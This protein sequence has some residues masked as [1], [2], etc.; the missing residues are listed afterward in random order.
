MLRF[1]VKFACGLGVAYLAV[2]APAMANNSINPGTTITGASGTAT[3]TLTTALTGQTNEPDVTGGNVDSFWYTWV[4]PQTGNVVFG[5][6]NTT[7]D[8]TTNF[9]T[10]LGT[11]TS[12]VEPVNN[13]NLN[14]LTTVPNPFGPVNLLDDSTGCLNSAGNAF[15]TTN[16][17]AAVMGTTYHIRV[18][19]YQSTVGTAR[20]R[21]AYPALTVATTDNSATEG[22]PN[23]GAF[24][25]VANIFAHSGDITV[26]IGSSPQC[27]FSPTTL[28]FTP[29][30]WNV[31]QTVTAT[32]TDDSNVEG[33][34]TCTPSSITAA[35][36]GWAGVTGTAP[37]INITD[38][39]TA[40]FTIAKSVSAATI[41]AP[42]PLTYT[43]T[44]DNTGTGDLIGPTLTDAL[45]F[46]AT[47]TALTTGPTLVS[48]DTNSDGILQ[49]TETWV[50]GASYTV[51]QANIDTGGTFSNTATFDPTALPPQTSAA[52]TTTITQTSTMAMA[53]SGYFLLPAHD[54]NGD[55]LAGPGDILTYDYEVENTGNTT[56]SN[57]TVA[58]VHDG[59][60]APLPVPDDEVLLT[61][62][63]PAADS[64]DVT[65]SDQTW[66]V[67]APND[68]I[69]FRASY[70]VVQGD[71]DAQ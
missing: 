8:A 43:I 62:I 2:V 28:T 65:V 14:T 25:V 3:V 19:G 36:N 7:T 67:L 59:L 29:S 10:T 35:G 24:T 38:N 39:D 33:T 4:A 71:V 31:A 66:S 60:G 23:T 70:Q 41:A 51:T 68:K 52:A 16:G 57:I 48:G 56:L 37:T 69:R 11:F 45:T 58:D 32:A 47:P 12:S 30:N 22:A 46:N 55:G 63:A 21:W 6:C 49:S 54:L 5:T 44:V 61:D 42:G 13:A 9:D 64:T 20:L 34:H 40:S 18:D 15:A 27:T 50:Y 17:F 1:G 53:K 26:T